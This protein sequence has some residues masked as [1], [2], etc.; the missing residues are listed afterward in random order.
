MADGYK[1]KLPISAALRP[2][3]EGTVK[4][5]PGGM[6]LGSAMQGAMATPIKMPKAPRMPKMPGMRKLK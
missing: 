4:P 2:G 6:N 1:K 3:G 5:K